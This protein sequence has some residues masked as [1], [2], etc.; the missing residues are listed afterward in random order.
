MNSKQIKAKKRKERQ[1]A[2][3]KLFKKPVPSN[4]IK[5]SIVEE[6]NVSESSL[7]NRRITLQKMSFDASGVTL[8]S[9]KGTIIRQMDRN[10]WIKLLNNNDHNSVNSWI[11]KKKTIE[12]LLIESDEEAILEVTMDELASL[13]ESYTIH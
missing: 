12:A 5:S 2:K 4:I 7:I 8:K 9:L 6:E 3:K 11:H 10:L 1:K 13:Y